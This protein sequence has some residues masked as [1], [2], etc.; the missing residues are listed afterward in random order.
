MISNERHQREIE[1]QEVEEIKNWFKSSF[2]SYIKLGWL[3]RHIILVT[4]ALAITVLTNFLIGNISL[5]IV[6]SIIRFTNY[7]EKQAGLFSPQILGNSILFSGL[8]ASFVISVNFYRLKSYIKDLLFQIESANRLCFVDELTQL[9]NLRGMNNVLTKFRA[10]AKRSKGEIHL[11]FIDLNDLTGINDK[12]GHPGGNIALKEIARA[13]GKTIR[14]EDV[15]ARYG[16]DEFYIII[17]YLNRN[18]DNINKTNEIKNRLQSNIAKIHAFSPLKED[19]SKEDKIP[20]G[21]SVGIHIMNYDTPTD[22]AIRQA[23]ADMYKS[24]PPKK[25]K[26]A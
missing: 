23:S 26:Y 22:E 19:P 15:A 9:L 24:K 6:N 21:A 14:T 5:K 12:F 10:K 20:V 13:I 1:D 18:P 25:S 16:G 8:L 17:L 3:H 4:A 11:L 7:L 2:D